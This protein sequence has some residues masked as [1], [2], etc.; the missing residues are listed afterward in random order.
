MPVPK[1]AQGCPRV[2]KG[3]LSVQFP[4]T[5]PYTMAGFSHI[6]TIVLPIPP[7]RS[8]RG[9]HDRSGHSYFVL[10]ATRWAWA[11]SS[12]A[13][14]LGRGPLGTSTQVPQGRRPCITTL[15]HT[16]AYDSSHASF[17]VCSGE[18]D[19]P[20]NPT[21]RRHRKSRVPTDPHP[22]L[23]L[24]IPVVGA[25]LSALASSFGQDSIRGP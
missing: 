15:L 12:M 24:R 19:E 23:T 3:R 25:Q 9:T 5:T 4:L 22:R 1:G 18:P 13:T 2:P 7:K 6:L 21:Q 20:G 8:R 16:I 14:S 17:F 11:P 10:E